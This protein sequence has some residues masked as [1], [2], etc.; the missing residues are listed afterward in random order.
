MNSNELV[1]DIEREVAKQTVRARVAHI[2]S[3]TGAS[4][5]GEKHHRKPYPAE[6]P[7]FG[8]ACPVC[9]SK[10]V[11]HD[12]YVEGGMGTRTGIAAKYTCGGAW[13]E[14]PQIQTHTDKWWGHCGYLHRK[15]E[16]ARYVACHGWLERELVDDPQEMSDED[17]GQAVKELRNRIKDIAEGRKPDGLC[18]ESGNECHKE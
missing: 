16:E 14:K 4:S 7:S 3:A 18:F 11:E 2:N 12:E 9:L 1:L 8:A 5:Y 17:L 6:L 15:W 13:M 10:R